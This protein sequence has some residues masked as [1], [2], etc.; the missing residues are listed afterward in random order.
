MAKEQQSSK[1]NDDQVSTTFNS[2]RVHLMDKAPLLAMASVKVLDAMF[3]TG[4]RIKTGKN[5]V[6]IDMPS[7]KTAGGEYQDIAFP[8]SKAMRDELQAVVLAAYEAAKA[9]AEKQG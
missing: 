9:A 5:G 7:R 3:V 8:A 1:Q 4:I 2:V 6:Y